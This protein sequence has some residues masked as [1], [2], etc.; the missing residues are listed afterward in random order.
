MR[1]SKVLKYG[2]LSLATVA[3]LAAM[4]HFAWTFSGTGEWQRVSG[5]DGIQIS[6]LK[7]S[8]ESAL[9]Y[10]VDMRVEARLADVV[11]F[12]SETETG[13]DLGAYDIRRLEAVSAPPVFYAYD[14]YKLRLPEPFGELEVVIINQ[15]AQDPDTRT[16]RVNVNAAPNKLPPDASI[17]RV[18]HLSNCWTLTPLPGGGVNMESISEMDLGMPYVLANLA[19]PSVIQ[20]NFGNIRALLKLDK[21]KNKHPAFIAELA[22]PD[23]ADAPVTAGL[24]P[25]K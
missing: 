12:L 6:T 10:K 18:V 24:I 8:G 11:A 5:K 7:V 22:D 1:V 9:K 3:F 25:P 17:R 20:E 13:I 4:A 21:Y 15:Y 16:V 19:M 14:T 2:G 23:V